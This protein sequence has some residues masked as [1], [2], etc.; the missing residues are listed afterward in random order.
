MKGALIQNVKVMPYTLETAIDREGY[1]SAILAASVTA[2]TTAK[3]SVT[4]C[5]TESG[6]FIKANKKE[7]A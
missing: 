6:S 3:V 1:L 2:G 7:V 4:H 5:D